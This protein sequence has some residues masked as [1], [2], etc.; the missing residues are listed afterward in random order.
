MSLDLNFKLQFAE[1]V[2]AATGSGKLHW[3]PTDDDY[4]F[5]ADVPDG[6]LT[7]GPV[8]WGGGTALRIFDATG[9]VVEQME[10]AGHN[11][12]FSDSD[13]SKADRLRLGDVLSDLMDIARR[14]ALDTDAVLGSIL[15]DLK[16]RLRE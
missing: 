9:R 16:S 14:E 1:A 4:V 10:G 15:K 3:R 8:P 12:V 5:M 2:L 11:Q 7:I 13:E 6:A